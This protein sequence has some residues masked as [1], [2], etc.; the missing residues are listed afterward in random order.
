[1]RC[2]VKLKRVAAVCSDTGEVF[3]APISTALRFINFRLPFSSFR[4]ATGGPGPV[5]AGPLQAGTALCQVSALMT[6]SES[7]ACHDQSVCLQRF[8]HHVWLAC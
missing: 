4:Y 7:Q 6:I 3:T 5:Q 8:I 2:N 1:M